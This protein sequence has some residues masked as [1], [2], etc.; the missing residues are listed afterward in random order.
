MTIQ[1][2]TLTT[3][4]IAKLNEA[5]TSAYA[6]FPLTAVNDHVIRLSIMTEPYFWHFHPNSD[7][8]F[9]V[10]EGSLLIDLDNQ[11]IELLPQ[12]LFTV[13]KDV[14]HRTRPGGMRAVSLVFESS[15]LETIRT[16]N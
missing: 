11:T 2:Q 8:S 15:N 14:K 16:E 10:I 9:L 1:P 5:I 7:E 12:Q 4:D 13:P 3:I 6:N